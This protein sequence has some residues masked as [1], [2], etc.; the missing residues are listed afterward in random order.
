MRTEGVLSKLKGLGRADAEDLTP[1]VADAGLAPRTPFEGWDEPG[2]DTVW[3]VLNRVA[4]LDAILELHNGMDPASR[5]PPIDDSKRIA[6]GFDTNAI[7]R[8][9]VG[10]KGPDAVDYLRTEHLGPIIVPGQTVQEVFNNALAG[11]EPQVKALRKAFESLKKDAEAIG[12]GLAD[13]GLAVTDAVDA[14]V[15]T[16]GDWVDPKSQ[17]AFDG[18]LDVLRF[19]QCSYVPRAEFAALAQVR[20]ETKTPPGFR[21]PTQNHGDFFVWADFLYSLTKANLDDV[22]SVVFVTNDTKS[23]WSRN[24]TAHPILVAEATAVGGLPFRLWTLPE[25][26]KFVARFGGSGP[27]RT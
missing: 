25:F 22:E 17:E 20:K 14:L 6:F 9:G 21:D 7:F 19:G 4:P 13:A 27:I 11:A 15:E 5:R 8:V 24:G 23:D 3:G 12:L 26:H 1:I 10:P 16:H 18:A 2:L